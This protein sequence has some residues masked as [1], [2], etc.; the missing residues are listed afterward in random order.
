MATLYRHYSSLFLPTTAFTRRAGSAFL[1]GALLCS[2]QLAA[3]DTN[4]WL[5]HRYKQYMPE[6]QKAAD[7][8]A[9]G[10]RCQ[11]VVRGELLESK[12]VAEKPVFR[13]ICRDETLQTYASVI[14]GL[15]LEELHASGETRM[16]QK[17]RHLPHYDRAC[18][19]DLKQKAER[20]KKPRFPEGAELEPTLINGDRV[21]FEVDFSS[22]SLN[23]TQLQYRGYCVFE[24]MAQYQTEIRPRPK[25]KPMVP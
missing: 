18:L 15:S 12:S 21:E 25:Q 19:K 5:P 24:N 1:S 9:E 6:L 8:V 17:Q 3:A 7:K 23:G 10:E 11:N 20:M 14:D 13:I 4:L 2:A 22:Q 16:Q